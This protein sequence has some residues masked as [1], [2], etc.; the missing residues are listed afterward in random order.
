M[1]LLLPNIKTI[2]NEEEYR[3]T[4]Y[5]YIMA[6][7]YKFGVTIED[8]AQIVYDEQKKYNE[9][10]TIEYAIEGVK[11]VLAK[12]E[13]QHGL[14][15][16]FYL[17]EQAEKGLLPFPLQY[18]V[19]SD[20]GTFGVDET[21]AKT[22]LNEYGSIADSNWGYLDKVKPGIIGQLNDAQKNGTGPVT[23]FLDDMLSAIVA[24][25]EGHTAHGTAETLYE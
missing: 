6:K 8:L 11:K 13:V 10:L 16:A 18:L 9:K 14:L 24:G 21:L 2:T 1:S 20:E 5:S 12:R 7:L 15:V 19:E 3:G 23:T 22:I 25:A 4:K 17:D